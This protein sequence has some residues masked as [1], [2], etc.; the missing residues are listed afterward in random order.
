MA[1]LV[2][3]STGTGTSLWGAGRG[4]GTA[5][6]FY[7]RALPWSLAAASSSLRT[8]TISELAQI[9]DARLYLELQERIWCLQHLVV[10]T[11]V[12]VFP[13]KKTEAFVRSR[14]ERLV[15]S[16]LH[17]FF[18]ITSGS[19][20]KQDVAFAPRRLGC[21]TAGAEMRERIVALPRQRPLVGNI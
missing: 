8:P 20:M 18:A 11:T 6:V 14:G 3:C 16:C 19:P 1:G 12:T 5:R 17:S 9:S 21:R 15:R 13:D 7:H 4:E 2:A 10:K